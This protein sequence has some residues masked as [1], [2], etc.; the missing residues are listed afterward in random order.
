M[1]LA[2]DKIR[3]CRPLSENAGRDFD[4]SADAALF[5]L[6][7]LEKLRKAGKDD[8]GGRVDYALHLREY[9]LRLQSGKKCLTEEDKAILLKLSATPPGPGI[10]S[11]FSA[12]IKGSVAGAIVGGFGGMSLGVIAWG[13]DRFSG[14]AYW[15]AAV[16][17]F[18]FGLI[19][20]METICE[21]EKLRLAR[22][23]KQDVYEKHKD[24]IL[25]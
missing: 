13:V 9:V 25:G 21:P 24:A 19:G 14:V 1:R 23:L 18:L 8:S 17:A 12:V 11:V 10:I 20:A 16:V 7:R 6:W 2:K 5:M 3:L 4:K 22:Y 15:G